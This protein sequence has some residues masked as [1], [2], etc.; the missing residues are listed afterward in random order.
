MLDIGIIKEFLQSYLENIKLPKNINLDDLAGVFIDYCENDYYDW[1]KDNAN[2]FF[3]GNDG[4]DWNIIAEKIQKNKK[5]QINGS[6]NIPLDV[7]NGRIKSTTPTQSEFLPCGL[8][9]T[10]ARL[11]NLLEHSRLVLCG[12]L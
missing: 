12:H 8:C 2:S 4:I 5:Q 10:K 9:R 11:Q 3:I 1:L 6:K 7:L